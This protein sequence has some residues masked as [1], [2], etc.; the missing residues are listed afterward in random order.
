MAGQSTNLLWTYLTP[1]RIYRHEVAV[2]DTA[3]GGNL[4]VIVADAK[5]TPPSVARTARVPT[6]PVVAARTRSCACRWE[7]VPPMKTPANCWGI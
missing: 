6:V 1:R 4:P 7:P 5:N 2:A 3:P